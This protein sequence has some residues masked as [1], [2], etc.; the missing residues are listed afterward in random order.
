[1]FSEVRDVRKVAEDG[2][3]AA[4]DETRSFD[5]HSIEL[6]ICAL[7]MLS[8]IYLFSTVSLSTTSLTCVSYFFC[9]SKY[10]FET[11]L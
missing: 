8:N 7:N 11:T 1:M 4:E 6:Y 5:I 2:K 3:K 10:F 9:F